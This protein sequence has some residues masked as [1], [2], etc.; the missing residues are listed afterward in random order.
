MVV[1]DGAYFIE[2]GS[3]PEGRV[4]LVPAKGKNDLSSRFAECEQ[5]FVTVAGEMGKKKKTDKFDSFT[6]Q[7]IASHDE[8]ARRAYELSHENP[9]YVEGNWFRAENEL[10]SL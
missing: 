1:A 5:K 8:I 9:S 7:N 10:L 6:V 3:I 4:Q 2:S